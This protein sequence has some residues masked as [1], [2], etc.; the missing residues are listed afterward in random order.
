MAVKTAFL[1]T[2]LCKTGKIPEVGYGRAGLTR[3]AKNAISAMISPELRLLQ[4]GDLA[5][6]IEVMLN[7]AVQHELDR[8]GLAW[9]DVV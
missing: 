3:I 8:V 9:D 7:Q 2:K 1:P 6:M 4:Q 5:G